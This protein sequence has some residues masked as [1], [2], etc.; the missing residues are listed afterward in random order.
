MI[1][2]TTTE[3]EPDGGLRLVI[4]APMACVVCGSS[5]IAA[6]APGSE[7]KITHAD[8]GRFMVSRGTAARAWCAAC[9]PWRPA[10]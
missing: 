4:G 3:V 1:H 2:A 9:W 6:V 8:A 7:D 5:E 10:P